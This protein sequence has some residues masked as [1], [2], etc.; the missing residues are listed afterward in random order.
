MQIPQTANADWNRR[1]LQA[2]QLRDVQVYSAQ[3]VLLDHTGSDCGKLRVVNLWSNR[4]PVPAELLALARVVENIKRK[5]GSTVVQFLFVA[6]PMDQT[7]A[8][9]VID[10]GRVGHKP[11]VV[12]AGPCRTMVFLL[13]PHRCSKCRPSQQLGSLKLSLGSSDEV[14]PMTLLVDAKVVR[15]AFVGSMGSHPAELDGCDLS[16]LLLASGFR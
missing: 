9:E 15:Q 2:T 10:F 16:Q 1:R 8:Q 5:H 4:A 7:S 13:V 11:T 12:R 14:R 6:D 3:R